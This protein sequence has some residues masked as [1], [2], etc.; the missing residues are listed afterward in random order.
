MNRFMEINEQY[1]RLRVQ[2]AEL[3]EEYKTKTKGDVY[4]KRKMQLEDKAKDYIRKAKEIGTNGNIC[5]VH[6][7]RSRPSI[8]NQ[9]IMVQESF[10]LYFVNVSEEEASALV[11]LHVK[12]TISYS[13]KFIRPGVI[14]TS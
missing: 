9:T 8:K 7:K 4:L 2:M 1:E 3:V 14:I 10:N 5:H 6:G 11:K 13:I 12:N